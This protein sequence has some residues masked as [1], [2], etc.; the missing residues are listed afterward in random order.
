MPSGAYSLLV[1]EASPV[2]SLAKVLRPPG[3]RPPS[4]VASPA[5]PAPQLE[6]TAAFASHM[7]YESHLGY[8]LFE[9][10]PSLPAALGDRPPSLG[11]PSFTRAASWF[12]LVEALP[13]ETAE[14]AQIE[15]VH[16]AEG[17]G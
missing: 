8:A 13:F 9:L 15:C 2:R 6:Y 5:A 12:S 17:M 4:V 1:R 11:D 14:S 7:L 10:A 3:A 16:V